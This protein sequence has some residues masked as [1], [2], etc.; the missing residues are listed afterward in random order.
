MTD[1]FAINILEQYRENP[2]LINEIETEEEAVWL[3]KVLDMAIKALKQQPKTGHWIVIR[4]EFEF[5]GGIV[6]EPRGC[7]CSN[8]NKVVRFK[9]DFCPNCGADMRES[10]GD[11]YI[12]YQHIQPIEVPYN[13]MRGTLDVEKGILTIEPPYK[14]ESEK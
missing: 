10:E 11:D 7:K 13:I 3:D 2:T 6:N 4:E 1:E 9:S 12:P 8:C 5:M 14:A